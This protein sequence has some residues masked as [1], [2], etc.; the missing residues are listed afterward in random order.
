MALN[1]Y[2]HYYITDGI[3]ISFTAPKAFVIL[4]DVKLKLLILYTQAVSMYC[5]KFLYRHH[6]TT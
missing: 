1:C 4:N 3:Y 5:F 2:V 6:E